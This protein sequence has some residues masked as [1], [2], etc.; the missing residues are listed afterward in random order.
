ML[1]H[2]VPIADG[3]AATSPVQTYLDLTQAGEGGCEGADHLRATLVEW[4]R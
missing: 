2:V 4:P 1:D 3:I